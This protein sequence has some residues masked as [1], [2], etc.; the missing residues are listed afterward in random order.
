MKIKIKTKE[1][2]PRIDFQWVVSISIVWISSIFLCLNAHARKNT[3]LH[4]DK[5][6]QT[7][8]LTLAFCILYEA[9]IWNK[10]QTQK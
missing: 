8:K 4:A 1:N 9:R 3:Q 7:I 6:A 10:K 5:R 2:L